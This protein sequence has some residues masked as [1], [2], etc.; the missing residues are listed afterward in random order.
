MVGFTSISC[1]WARCEAWRWAR[2]PQLWKS[3]SELLFANDGGRGNSK[4]WTIAVQRGI[5]LSTPFSL[6]EK[7]NRGDIEGAKTWYPVKV[8]LLKGAA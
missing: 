4:D 5:V 3:R 8:T 6:Q 1:H 2:R 7:W